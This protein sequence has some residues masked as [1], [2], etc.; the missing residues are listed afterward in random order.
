[1]SGARLEA[2]LEMMS[3]V[4]GASEIT[5]AAYRRDLEEASEFVGGLAR[6]CEGTAAE[7]YRAIVAAWLRGRPL[8]AGP[9]PGHEAAA[10]W[11]STLAE[12]QRREW[13]RMFYTDFASCRLRA[14][15]FGGGARLHRVA[16]RGPSYPPRTP[17]PGPPYP[18]LPVD[19]VSGAPA[20]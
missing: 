10:G 13:L 9:L 15:H 11:F 12:S 2:F 18:T 1:M 7:G 5:L 6:P 19:S 14:S 16:L 8:P 20:P 4:R 3:A 17:V